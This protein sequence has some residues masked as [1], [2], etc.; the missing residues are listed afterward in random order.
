M[1]RRGPCEDD[2]KVL[3]NHVL[4][5][6]I[7]EEFDLLKKNIECF[8]DE[9]Q[10]R[11]EWL[12]FEIANHEVRYAPELKKALEFNNVD[13]P[14]IRDEPIEFPKGYVVPPI[15][16]QDDQ[17]ASLR[18]QDAK[19]PY[20]DA[21]KWN[22]EMLE[23]KFKFSFDMHEQLI[24]EVA[25]I[26]L[27]N[28]LIPR[29]FAE[30]EAMFS[31][32]LSHPHMAYTLNRRMDEPQSTPMVITDA[33][34][35]AVG[36]SDLV[37][38]IFAPQVAGSESPTGDAGGG[39]GG[40]GGIGTETGTL[41]VGVTA[42]PVFIFSEGGTIQGGAVATNDERFQVFDLTSTR[43]TGTFSLAILLEEGESRNSVLQ[44]VPAALDLS[45]Q[46]K[47]LDTLAIPIKSGGGLLPAAT[48]SFNLT[49]TVRVTVDIAP[50]SIPANGATQVIDIEFSWVRI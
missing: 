32:L 25:D 43:T 16:D 30:V 13:E 28:S 10:D 36:G 41:K 18:M 9:S 45:I 1:K 22:K 4:G 17:D 35:A 48:T 39:G 21:I 33:V 49:R 50:A 23:F 47:L 44:F 40:T 2:G 37:V 19:F 3:W 20:L 8:I 5:T 6:Q 29:I 12:L 24:K 31:D 14:E 26:Q 42:D 46:N 7:Q 11:I 15:W 27:H 34:D 38:K